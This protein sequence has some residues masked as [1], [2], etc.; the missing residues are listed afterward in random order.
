MF[1][2]CPWD[3]YWLVNY[4]RSAKFVSW[5]CG[6]QSYLKYEK[7][8]DQENYRVFNC[9]G[10]FWLTRWRLTNNLSWQVIPFVTFKVMKNIFHR[11]HKK[12]IMLTIMIKYAELVYHYC[13]LELQWKTYLSILRKELHFKRTPS[14]TNHVYFSLVDILIS[15]YFNCF[16]NIES[17]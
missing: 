2:L 5:P 4:D 11:Y 16:L 9:L 12:I 6:Y 1:N 15:I 3:V 13:L 7:Y 17:K 14:V 10:I 8:F